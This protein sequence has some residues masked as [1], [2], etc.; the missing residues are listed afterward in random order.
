MPLQRYILFC[1]LCLTFASCGKKES[2]VSTT[3]TAAIDTNQPAKTI[4]ISDTNHHLF[5]RPSP[6]SVERYH[7][8]D[9]MTMSSKDNSP[10]G[11]GM[12]H[13]A[14]STTE[15]YLHQTVGKR[16]RDSSVT[17]TYR[18][19]SIRLSSQQDTSKLTYSSN[20]LHD[21]MNDQYREFNILVGKNFTVRANKYGDLDSMLDVSE[22]VAGLLAPVPD[23]TRNQPRIRQMATR[24]AE[25]VANAYIMRVLV[26]NPTRALVTDT[27]WRDSS[28]V[29]LDVAA[30]LS[31]P[32]HINA[33]ETVRG[34]EKRGDR[35]LAV[36]EDNT[37]TTPRKREFQEGPTT[38]TI[39]DFMA[40]SHSVVH[41]EDS[42][43]LLFYRGMQEKRNFTLKIESKEHPGE[44]R[45]VTQNGTENLVTEIL[46]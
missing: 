11:P 6:G 15:F 43:G 29:N 30:G 5:F 17:L 10:N 33:S 39:Q 23:S 42:T 21:R 36:L 2:A 35:V 3:N 22:I 8:I 16:G 37:T 27:T 19:D 14:T 46:E 18:V 38:A 12:S 44:A 20:D 25:E 31:F 34:L 41:I 1:F 26:H 24:Q 40:T 32:V 9:R 4:P 28:D 7:I 13:S 45:S